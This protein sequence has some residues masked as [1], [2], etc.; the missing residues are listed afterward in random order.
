MAFGDLLGTLSGSG[1]SVTNPSVASGSVVVAV[2]DLIV[3]VMGEQ[4]SL[5]VS[6]C[7]DNLGNS[8]TAQ[9]V[10]TDAGTICGRMF[11]SRVT[12]A[13]T[14]TALN[15][16]A[17]ASTLNFTVVGACFAGPFTSPPIDANPA[18][19]SND[20]TSPFTCPATGTLAQA[21]ELVV[22][23]ATAGTLTA[24]DW[25]GSGVTKAIQATDGAITN[26]TIGRVV[27]SSTSTITPAYT[28]TAPSAVDVLGTA[29]FKSAAAGTTVYEF[30]E[31]PTVL[32]NILAVGY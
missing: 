24:T 5:T 17:T 23:W 2:G 22:A 26:A 32:H 29:S 19:A 1:L 13:G 27:V 4:N 31:S 11:Y 30:S 15:F 20:I 21:D 14:V 6:A 9:N 25:V 10:G 12:V 18:N 16:T 3:G 7:G 28:G 8:Y